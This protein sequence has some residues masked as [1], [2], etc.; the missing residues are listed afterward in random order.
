MQEANG[1]KVF[2]KFLLDQFNLNTKVN[3]VE[4]Y[5]RFFYV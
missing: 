1:I 2:F 3:D 5:Y 4:K